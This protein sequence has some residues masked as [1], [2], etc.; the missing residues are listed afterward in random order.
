MSLDPQLKNQ[1]A[2]FQEERKNKNGSIKQMV[3]G[4]NSSHIV[5]SEQT[6]TLSN[7]FTWGEQP[8]ELKY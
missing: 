4:E 8:T 6:V 3:R 7:L 2:V 1:K 5:K